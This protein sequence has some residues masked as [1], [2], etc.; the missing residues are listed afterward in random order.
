MARASRLRLTCVSIRHS[1]IRTLVSNL[2]FFVSSHTSISIVPVLTHTS[3][4][5]MIRDDTRFGRSIPVTN[6]KTNDILLIAYQ[7]LGAQA[8]DSSNGS[9]VFRVSALGNPDLATIVSTKH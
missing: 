6:H 8:K 7:L 2:G 5:S 4:I 9:L 1:L 3:C